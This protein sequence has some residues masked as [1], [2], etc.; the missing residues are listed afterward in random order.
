MLTTITIIVAGLFV[1]GAGLMYAIHITKK[2]DTSQARTDWIKYAVFFGVVVIFIGAA[3]IGP[4]A[5]CGLLCGVLAAA[6]YEVWVNFTHR[7]KAVVGPT[8]LLTAL[9]ALGLFHLLFFIDDGWSVWCVFFFLLIFI[10]DSYAQLIGRLIGKNKLC[11]R[12][13]PNKT[14]EGLVGGIGMTILF[15]LIFSSLVPGFTILHAL[16]LAVATALAAVA[17]DLVFSMFK[18]KIGIKDFSA[19]LPGHGGILDRFDSL[20]VAS[21]VFVWGRITLDH[22]PG[23]MS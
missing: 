2:P 10:T 23:G 19:L 21:P 14:I 7:R 4:I 18:R 11:P 9:I 13:S 16:V 17:G 1:I 3:L 12:I 15:A 5:V 22:I 20:I 6:G 8:C